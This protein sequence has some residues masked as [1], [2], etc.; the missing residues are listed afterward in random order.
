MA[1]PRLIDARG[2]EF[3]RAL[4]N[5]RIGG[6]CVFVSGL[7]LSSAGND[8]ELVALYTAG[9][10]NWADIIPQ[11]DGQGPLLV[12]ARTNQGYVMVR[13]LAEEADIAQQR[14]WSVPATS[15]PARC[16]MAQRRSSIFVPADGC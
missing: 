4:I 5:Q 13:L 3:L 12:I 9:A 15:L 14:I 7:P 11:M 8:I 2:H 16:R 10:L 6:G 1:D